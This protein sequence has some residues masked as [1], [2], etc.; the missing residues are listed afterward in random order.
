MWD[1]WF[2]QVKPLADPNTG[3]INEPLAGSLNKLGE[4]TKLYVEHQTLNMR[5][6][7]DRS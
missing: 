4:V 1:K 3:F 7:Q 2:P 5:I 6:F